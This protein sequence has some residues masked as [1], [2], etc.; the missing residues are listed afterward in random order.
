MPDMWP[1][2]ILGAAI[3]L[4]VV[5]SSPCCLEDRRD[6][7]RLAPS[8]RPGTL[9][10]SCRRS[11]AP[12]RHCPLQP[13][14]ISSRPSEEGSFFERSLILRPARSRAGGDAKPAGLYGQL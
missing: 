14:D 7:T 6:H 11:H 3:L 10:P 12:G 2:I 1:F 5:L 13:A 4:V 8:V 9:A